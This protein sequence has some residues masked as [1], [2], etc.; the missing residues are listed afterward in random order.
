MR[1]QWN[2]V[3]AKEFNVPKYYQCVAVLMIHWADWLD[4]DL[5]CGDEVCRLTPESHDDVLIFSQTAELESVF[6]DKFGFTTRR[7]I[8]HCRDKHPQSQVNLAVAKFL[9]D[10]DGSHRTTLLI[11]Y[12]SGHGLVREESGIERFYISGYASFRRQRP[13]L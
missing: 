5:H 12:Y 1:Q 13:T 3:V 6:G 9:S 7:V 11:V 4:P 8:L 10:Y 2:A